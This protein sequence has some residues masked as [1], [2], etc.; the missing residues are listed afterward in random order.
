MLVGTVIGCFPELYLH[1]STS[2]LGDAL[3]P[4]LLDVGQLHERGDY[5]G[6]GRGQQQQWARH[7]QHAAALPLPEAAPRG[8]G[9]V[10][11]RLAD[12]GIFR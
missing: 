5:H 3:F 10:S 6:G 8:A 12:Q 2:P 9:G 1:I 4:L 7:G 11:G